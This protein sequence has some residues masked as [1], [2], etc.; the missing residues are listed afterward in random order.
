M[1]QLTEVAV[2]RAGGGADLEVA[3]DE[4]P[5]LKRELIE[6]WIAELNA[7][8]RTMVKDMKARN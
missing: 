4:R 8:A 7:F 5:A 6:M 3:A 1:S 2:F